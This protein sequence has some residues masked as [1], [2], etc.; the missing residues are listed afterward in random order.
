M[1]LSI[2]LL[3]VALAGGCASHRSWHDKN[4]NLKLPRIEHELNFYVA[5]H[6]W[7]ATNN[8]YV[9]PT[10]FRHGEPLRATV[11]WKEE[12]TLL[13]YAELEADATHDILAWSGHDLK[14]DRDTVDTSD[15]IGGSNYLETHRQWVESMERCVFKG[16]EFRIL[17]T[18]AQRVFPN[19]QVEQK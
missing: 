4:A 14:L 16:R 17:A 3:I 5:T 18:D 12:R 10:D 11:Y 7:H 13:S 9:Y 8:F 6:P 1:R 15:E 19:Q 2:L